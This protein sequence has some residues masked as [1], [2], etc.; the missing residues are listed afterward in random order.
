[1]PYAD[2]QK[3]KEATAEWARRNRDKMG[4]YNTKWA[5]SN[6]KKKNAINRRAI[7]RVGSKK[8]AAHNE[9]RRVRR[10]L[11]LLKEMEAV[12]ARVT[13]E[14]N[15]ALAAEAKARAERGYDG[16]LTPRGF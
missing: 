10:K 16:R 15:A 11:A 5:K 14:R 7:G 4:R 6:R 1:M 12:R 8:R 9:R 3:A 13:A 2:P